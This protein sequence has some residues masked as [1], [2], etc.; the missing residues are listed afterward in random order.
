MPDELFMVSIGRW[1]IE[2]SA[3]EAHAVRCEM[4]SPLYEL[5]SSIEADRQGRCADLLFDTCTEHDETLAKAGRTA[6][7]VWI[8]VG[9]QRLAMS[10]GESLRLWKTLYSIDKQRRRVESKPQAKP[11]KR[12]EFSKMNHAT[13]KK[14]LPRESAEVEKQLAVPSEQRAALRCVLRGLTVRQAV[15]H[16]SHT[17]KVVETI[18]HERR[19][20]KTLR[21]VTGY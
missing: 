7:G 12:D 9:E 5:I 17:R 14:R 10:A 19:T 11:P 21:E 6:K 13:L 18:R 8:E 2:L 15:K 1:T 16:I 4:A 3:D 20:A